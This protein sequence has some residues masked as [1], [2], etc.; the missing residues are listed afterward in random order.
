LPNIVKYLIHRWQNPQPNIMEGEQWSGQISKRWELSKASS[1]IL[2]D[3]LHTPMHYSLET[4]Y[5]SVV[6]EPQLSYQ[7]SKLVTYVV[8]PLIF[9][10]HYLGKMVNK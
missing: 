2:K 3:C 8:N 1:K 4:S 7:G 10:S 5:N 6:D 9:P